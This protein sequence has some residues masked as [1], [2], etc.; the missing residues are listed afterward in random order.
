MAGHKR[1]PND[2]AP[3]RKTP[4]DIRGIDK[5][6]GPVA[7]GGVQKPSPSAGTN[8]GGDGA[9]GV[10]SVQISPAA[11]YLEQYTSGPQV[12]VEKVA[13]A[14]QAIADGTMDSDAKLS[15]ALDRLLDDLLSN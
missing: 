14:R 9:A 11:R 1:A 8:A 10:D 4:V 2:E 6:S 5:L 3:G 13:A 7:V 12:R 15:V